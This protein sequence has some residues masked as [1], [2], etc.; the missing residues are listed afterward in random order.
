M[1]DICCELVSTSPVEGEL[2]WRLR[3]ETP[4]ASALQVKQ[5]LK[6][7]FTNL[8]G[9]FRYWK[10]DVSNFDRLYVEIDVLSF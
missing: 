6:M 1:D 4:A 7:M 9:S 2:R 10:H 3:A 5:S 8:T